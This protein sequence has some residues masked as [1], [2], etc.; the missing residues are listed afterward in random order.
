MGRSSVRSASRI[1]DITTRSLFRCK[2]C[3]TQFS[4]KLGTIFED[5]PLGLDKWFVAV[6]ANSNRST[7]SHELARALKV[8]QKTAWLM[9]RRIR[10]RPD[11]AR[12]LQALIDADNEPD[13]PVDEV[14]EAEEWREKL[15]QHL[16]R[17]RD[18]KI[19]ELKK[20]DVACRCGKLECE[21]CG[22]VFTD[23]YGEWGEGFI[24]CHHTRQLATIHE[25]ER[26][27][28]EDLAVVCANCHRMLH[29]STSVLAVAQLREIVQQQREKKKG[30]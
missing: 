9:Y 13:D 17:E 12:L 16:R 14:Y 28:L 7:S 11:T 26:T 4:Y 20:T 19:V 21:V 29:K 10:E 24:E 6:W 22:F 18:R 15:V 23:L 25:G 2:D 5:S 1:G 8:T 27:R 3:R 30:Q